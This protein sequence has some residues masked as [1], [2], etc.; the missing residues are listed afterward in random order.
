MHEN[1]GLET[2]QV[3]KKL[4]NLEKNAWGRGLRERGECLGGEQPQIDWER[5]RKWSLDRTE[6]TYRSS[7]IL[8]R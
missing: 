2:Y 3:K 7:V 6:P 4:I 5:S 1:E 8:D